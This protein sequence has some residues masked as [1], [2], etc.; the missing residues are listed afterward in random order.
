[1]SLDLSNAVICEDCGYPTHQAAI[2][3]ARVLVEIH[4]DDPEFTVEPFGDCYRC[5]YLKAAERALAAEQRV[6]VLAGLLHRR[7]S[8]DPIEVAEALEGL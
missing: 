2:D 7:H 4:R 6:S 8:L 5:A 1:M 3:I